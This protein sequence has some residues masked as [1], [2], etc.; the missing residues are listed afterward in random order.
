MDAFAASL[1]RSPELFPH[2]LEPGTDA[3][4]LIRVTEGEYAAASFLDERILGRRTIS[5]TIS[6]ANLVGAVVQTRLQE[7]CDFIFHIGHVGSTLLSRLL[8]RH[9]A[10]FALREPGIL[11]TLA[12][13][14][15]EPG[16]SP[17]ARYES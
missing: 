6:C 17:P 11:R 3:V 5:R 15:F 1:E 9:R 16:A 2:S 12:Q 7:C 10:V 4:T 13:M 8:G 14:H